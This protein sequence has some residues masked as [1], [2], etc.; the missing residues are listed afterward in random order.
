MTAPAVEVEDVMP[1]ARELMVRLGRVPGKDLLK[2][3]LRVGYPK[4]VLI[5]A[6]LQSEEG[7]GWDLDESVV[8]P[9]TPPATEEGPLPE[10]P[11]SP[12]VGP[13]QEEAQEYPLPPTTPSTLP[14]ERVEEAQEEEPSRKP[15]KDIAVWPIIGI[16]IPAYVAI[17]G[18]WVDLGKMTGFGPVRVLPGIKDNLVVNLAITLPIGLE[19]YASYAIYVWLHRS[20]SPELRSF[21]RTSAIWSL[22]AG[23][24]G[25]VVYHLL[26]AA[27]AETAPWPITL[28][29]S[30]IPVA[31]LGMGA[32]LVHKVREGKR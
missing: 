14:P 18:G 21:A 13:I 9:S 32:Y 24:F 3:E 30:L 31:V 8:K 25:Q 1:A 11:V 28:V 5:Q 27:G 17:W 19:I 10:A 23:G 26:K 15:P 20:A 16:L 7:Q 29:V 22:I 2:K 6:A 4:A 12:G